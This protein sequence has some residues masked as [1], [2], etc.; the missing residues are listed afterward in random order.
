MTPSGQVRD[1]C[2]RCH[3]I[4]T[5]CERIV[6]DQLGCQRCTRLGK[7]CSYSPPGQTG[8]PPGGRKR[9][10]P[11]G[12]APEGPDRSFQQ[13]SRSPERFDDPG[14]INVVPCATRT[15]LPSPDVSEPAIFLDSV[16]HLTPPE[17]GQYDVSFGMQ[18]FAMSPWR[19]YAPDIMSPS[20][21]TME[22]QNETNPMYP[23]PPPSHAP[24]QAAMQP[25]PPEQQ[26]S[27]RNQYKATASPSDTTHMQL[28]QLANLQSR[29]LVLGK[30]VA[31]ASDSRSSI[32]EVL[33][34]SE[35]FITSFQTIEPLCYRLPVRNTNT[36]TP[37]QQQK[38]TKTSQTAI[39][40]VSNCYL[41]LID[42][43][44]TLVAQLQHERDFGEA[45]ED[46]GRPP[47]Q[48][49][50]SIGS[51]GLSLSRQAAAEVHLHLVFRMFDRLAVSLGARG[52]STDTSD[53]DK[54]A[55]SIAGLAGRAVRDLATLE[56]RIS[57]RRGKAKFV[58][59][60]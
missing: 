11:D 56:E 43:F 32:E 48:T 49:L 7:P 46:R 39:F 42:I 57:D 45:T 16:L 25:Y 6:G 22:T 12:G 47:Q 37:T 55:Q 1:A 19:S 21:I 40:L 5:R 2:D 59:E 14:N 58:I 10:E 30:S 41:N 3:S 33:I 23:P 17:P 13:S 15:A 20:D 9:K 28:M 38:E 26:A 50:V 44:E 36:M 54:M 4:K 52:D 51:T 35:S 24:P 53:G 60:E 18:D 29:L 31:E 27:S 34:V 8:R